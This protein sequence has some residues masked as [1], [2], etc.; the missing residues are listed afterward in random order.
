MLKMLEH[1][2]DQVEVM[3][4]DKHLQFQGLEIKVILVE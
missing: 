3:D 4:M 1:L 2:E